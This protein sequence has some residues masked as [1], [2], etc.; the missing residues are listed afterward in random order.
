M[1]RLGRWY[2]AP[3]P[4]ERLA[5][6][7]ALIGGY[8]L[9]YL[10]GRFLGFV[11]FSRFSASTFKPVGPVAIIEHPLPTVVLALLAAV[12]V[13]LGVAF[14][15]GHRFRVTGPAFAVL[16]LW[17]VSYRN[18][19]GM[20]FHTENLIVL[21][22]LVLGLSPG[23]ADVWARD[24][25]GRAPPEASGRYGWP[26]RLLCLVT[27]TT[28]VLA[29][30]AKLAKSGTGWITDDTLRGLV[31]FDNL[32]KIE[33]GSAHS[34]VGAWLVSVPW[35][36]TPLAAFSLAMELFAPV[37]LLSRRVGQ[38]WCVLAWGFHFGVIVLMAIM[39][40]YQLFF[41]AYASFFDVEKLGRRV[42]RWRERRPGG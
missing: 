38:I 10:V 7:R 6:L 27:V 37:A 16:Y 41:V 22:V 28:Y 4:A 34:P 26:I 25:R 3:A 19:W 17:V 2:F 21:H 20:P 36:F 30:Y 14:V 31:A 24:A 9:V 5:V 33:L 15:A 23:A 32:R 12:T 35:L 40:H 42:V 13:V 29:G 39:F 18:S 1:S 8:A 11:D